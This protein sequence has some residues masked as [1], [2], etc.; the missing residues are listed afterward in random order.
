MEASRP[1]VFGQR[2]I[3]T[4]PDLSA[5]SSKMCLIFYY[6]MLGKS[7]GS[8]NVFVDYSTPTR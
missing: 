7:I 6:H 3:I 5:S 2:T 1:Q 8:L 4:T